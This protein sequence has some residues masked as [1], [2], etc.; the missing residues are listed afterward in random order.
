MQVY[1]SL[2]C[3]GLLNVVGFS[4][5]SALKATVEVTT[6][7]IN[8]I[9]NYVS[10]ALSGKQGL[11]LCKIWYNELINCTTVMLL[12]WT[13]QNN[14]NNNYYNFSLCAWSRPRPHEN[15]RRGCVGVHRQER[16]PRGLH[17][18]HD[19]WWELFKILNETLQS[20][21]E[22]QSL[23]NPTVSKELNISLSVLCVFQVNLLLHLLPVWS[24]KKVFNR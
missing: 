11:C 24:L 3:S 12:D 8:K 10:S 16:T 4:P 1:Y 6:E 2:T 13:D 18:E 20:S 7:E 17:V 22:K 9:I 14:N 23:C 15:N 21:P 5:T 19:C